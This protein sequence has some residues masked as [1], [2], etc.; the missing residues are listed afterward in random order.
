MCNF[1]VSAVPTPDQVR[2]SYLSRQNGVSL[3]FNT[4]AFRRPMHYVF[5]LFVRPSDPPFEAQNRFFPPIHFSVG[6]S[7]QAWPFVWTS[8]WRGFRAFPGKHIQRN[9]LQFR[10]LMYPDELQSWLG[11]VYGLFIFLFL[12]YFD[13]VKWVKFGVSR[14]FIET[15]KKAWLLWIIPN[16]HLLIDSLFQIKSFH[17]RRNI[18]K[19][20]LINTSHIVSVSMC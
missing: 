19:Y 13:L 2:V 12:H 15:A 3:H 5:A 11:F 4:P 1:V 18:S 16:K 20:H 17:F 8:V 14:H 10:M 7:A 6:P 9:G